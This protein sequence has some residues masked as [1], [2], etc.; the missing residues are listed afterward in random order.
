MNY[1]L[2]GPLTNAVI[3]DPD[4]HTRRPIKGTAQLRP[5]WTDLRHLVI[6]KDHLTIDLPI[7]RPHDPTDFFF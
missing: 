1:D 2:Q 7:D 5:E 4:A 3:K 6:I